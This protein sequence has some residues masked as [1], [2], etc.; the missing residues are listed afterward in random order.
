M[1][2]LNFKLSLYHEIK[3]VLL[4]DFGYIEDVE[5][6][7]LIEVSGATNMYQ[8]EHQEIAYADPSGRINPS[9]VII[10]D[11]AR[12]L[13]RSEFVMDYITSVVTLNATPSG[14][15]TSDYTFYPIKVIDAFP[16][17]EEFATIEL[18]LI[19]VDFDTQDIEDYAI[20]QEA[21]YWNMTYFVDIFAVNDAMRLQLMDR[22]QRTLKRWIPIID[23]ESQMPLTY[24]GE[25]N[26]NFDWEGQFLQW[27]KIRSK[28]K[29]TLLNMGSVSP[30]EKY[31]AVIRGTLTSIH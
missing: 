8:F 19:S 29:G 23:F 17:A 10:Y 9:G 5:D 1:S 21:S 31:R 20:G 16:T 14:T 3:T 15:V 7:T 18:P 13:E 25:I 4:P 27:L 26:S 24:D 12:Q 22:L 2:L 30:K 6:E 28:P 11:E